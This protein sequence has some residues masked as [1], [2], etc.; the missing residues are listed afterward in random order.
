MN[1]NIVH[2]WT[3]TYNVSSAGDLLR[4]S[5][6]MFPS[7]NTGEWRSGGVLL[8]GRLQIIRWDGTVTWDFLYRSA[9]YC[10]HH[11]I[12]PVYYTNDPTEKPN[13]MVVCYTSQGD[14]ATELKPTGKT[15]A[16]VVWE[17][18]A[19]DHA[20]NGGSGKPEL[21]DLAKGGMGGGQQGGAG[22]EWNH[23]NYVS[24]NRVLNQLVI[25]IKSFNE[26][27]IID[28]STTTAEAAGHTGGKYGKGGDILYRWGNPSNYG[29]TG[30]Q[31]LFGQHSGSWVLDTFPGTELPL[32]GGGN[33]IAISNE[34]KKAVEITPPGTKNGIYPRTEGAA[35]APSA[36]VWIYNIDG[37]A[38]N[39]GSIE[40]LPNGNTLICTGG[41]GGNFGGSTEADKII[42]VTPNGEIVWNLDNV[43]ASKA[44]RYALTY[45]GGPK[46][47]VAEQSADPAKIGAPLVC[48]SAHC[49]IVS[50]GTGVRDA[51]VAIY[52][53]DGKEVF[54][55]VVSGNRFVW[56]S[57]NQAPGHYLLTLSVGDKVFRDRCVV[58]E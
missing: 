12:E 44:A 40:R 16:D 11:D 53:I 48:A 29:A 34:T 57:K 1:K 3:S 9:D 20:V 33:L 21:L 4:D 41:V 46:E 5:S 6:V 14:K 8:G 35:F 13:V 15:T 22:V 52:S 43:S 10:P 24:F 36:P 30:A 38:Q 45:M 27:M 55:N 23:M 26:M 28:H 2:T 42:E 49:T 25:D 58:S 51:R 18:K 19:S 32:P 56:D 17:W 47:T 39:E 54:R 50:F 37:M 31:Q 7:S